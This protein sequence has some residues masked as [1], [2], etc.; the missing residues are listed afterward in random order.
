MISIELTRRFKKAVRSAGR[1]KEVSD[2]IRKVIEGFGRPHVHA[3]LSIRKLGGRLYE[4]RAGLDWRLVFIASKGALVFDF[5]G[6]HDDVQNYL[7]GGKA[8]KG[9]C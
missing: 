5:A 4:C 2:T 9:I 3:G 1:E 6:N 8:R 7:R